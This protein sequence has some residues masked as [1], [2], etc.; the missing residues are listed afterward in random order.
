MA[1]KKI[2][3]KAQNTRKQFKMRKFNSVATQQHLNTNKKK[4]IIFIIRKNEIIKKNFQLNNTK[5]LKFR[6]C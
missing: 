1:T 2:A 3:K 6:L 4:N 5:K